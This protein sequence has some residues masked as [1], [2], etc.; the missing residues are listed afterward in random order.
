MAGSELGA[1]VLLRT[2][3]LMERRPWQRGAVDGR[4]VPG[5]ASAAVWGWREGP[6]RRLQRGDPDLSGHGFTRRLRRQLGIP[7]AVVGE[8]GLSLG[9]TRGASP[10]PSSRPGERARAEPQ[11]SRLIGPLFLEEQH[12]CP[13][14]ADR[15]RDHHARRSTGGQRVTEALSRHRPGDLVPRGA[16]VTASAYDCPSA[17]SGSTLGLASASTSRA[18]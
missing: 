11:G 17:S 5:P 13:I 18:C 4:A 6:K 1:A 9:K 15:L 7:G 12:V 16:L 8:A 3:P 10:S 14:L 2:E